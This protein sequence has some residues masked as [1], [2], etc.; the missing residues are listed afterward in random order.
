M[1]YALN[2]QKT[3]VCIKFKFL[4]VFIILIHNNFYTYDNK[5]NNEN[6]IVHS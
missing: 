2:G 6:K 4:N 5:V 3:I 1:L